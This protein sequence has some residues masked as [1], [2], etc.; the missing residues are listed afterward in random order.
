MNEKHI[1]EGLVHK[2]LHVTAVKYLSGHRKHRDE[3]V[4]EPKKQPNRIFVLEELATKVIMGFRTTGEHKFRT[5]LGFKQYH[6]ILTKKQ[7]VLTNIKK[8]I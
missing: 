3:L 2:N 8:L 1:E 4:D 7:S 6:I 5:R